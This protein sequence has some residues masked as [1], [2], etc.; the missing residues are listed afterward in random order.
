MCR[1]KMQ[2]ANLRLLADISVG[3]FTDIERMNIE[4]ILDN[5]NKKAVLELGRIKKLREKREAILKQEEKREARRIKEEQK[6]EARMKKIN[7]RRR[8]EQITRAQIN[9]N[10]I[11]CAETR[12]EY[13]RCAFSRFDFPMI[14]NA[15][16]GSLLYEVREAAM[17]NVRLQYENDVRNGVR[18][19][20]ERERIVFLEGK[21][22]DCEKECGICY[23]TKMC[24]LNYVCTHSF[25]KP[26]L[27]V[28]S[29]CCPICRSE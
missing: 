16:Q 26:C 21:P 7:R 5:D 25:C 24:I 12:E 2:L 6:L 23:E 19:K 28:W 8:T 3:E 18:P 13:R 10:F 29:K 1:N 15:E 17:E 20:K 14:L 22:E 4:K 9:C 11:Q 27:I